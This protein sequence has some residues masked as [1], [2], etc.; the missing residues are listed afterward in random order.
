MKDDKKNV[1]GCGNAAGRSG[2]CN[3]AIGLSSSIT[4]TT[5]FARQIVFFFN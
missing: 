2:K 1:W 4:I 5:K 3:H